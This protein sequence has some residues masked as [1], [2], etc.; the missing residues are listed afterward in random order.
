MTPDKITIHCSATPNGKNV[1][2]DEIKKWHTD[3][4]PKGR[5]WA[6]IGYHWVID[7]AGALHHGRDEKSIGAGVEG[8]NVG[9]VHVCLIGT[10]AFMIRTSITYK[11][12]LCKIVCSIQGFTI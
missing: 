12:V 8:A 9:N 10:N 1:S 3:P 4:P 7:T 11:I 5:G 2:F 6:D